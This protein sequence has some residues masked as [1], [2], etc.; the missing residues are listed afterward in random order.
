M[1]VL[2]LFSRRDM[3]LLSKLNVN[4]VS[5]CHSCAHLYMAVHFIITFHLFVHAWLLCYAYACNRCSG[6]S[7]ASGIRASTSGGAAASSGAGGAD[8]RRRS[9]RRSSWVP[10]SPTFLF[11]ERQAPEHSKSPMF[12]QISWVSFYC[13]WCIKYRNWLEPIVALYPYLVQIKSYES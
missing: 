7:H 1:G 5:S 3:H 4:L 2:F 6:G 10:R 9:Q 8:T 12:L 13:W 11:S